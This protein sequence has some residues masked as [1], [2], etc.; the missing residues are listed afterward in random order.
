MKKIVRLKGSSISLNNLG[1]VSF[2]SKNM[3]NDDAWKRKNTYERELSALV[4]CKTKW[5]YYCVGSHSVT[6][7]VDNKSVS[8][9]AK[10][11]SFAIRNIFDSIKHAD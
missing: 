4:H 11:R 5:H 2:L 7:Y 10:S 6:F 1:I 3:A 9:P 8:Q